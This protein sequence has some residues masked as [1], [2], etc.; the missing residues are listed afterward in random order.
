M[1]NTTSSMCKRCCERFV[2]H[3]TLTW[4][5]AGSKFVYTSDTKHNSF[6]LIFSYMSILICS[7]IKLNKLNISKKKKTFTPVNL[8]FNI[9]FFQLWN[10]GKGDMTTIDSG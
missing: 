4:L 1:I 7:K 10:G 5:V 9:A 2:V 3:I 8:F 6:M